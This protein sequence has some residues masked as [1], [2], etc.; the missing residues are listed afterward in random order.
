MGEEN[1]VTLDALND[2][3]IQLKDNGEYKE[4]IKAYVRYLAGRI[5]VL[6]EDHKKTRAFKGHEKILG[7]TH[8]LIRST[9]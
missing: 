1:V 6:G 8:H 7:M 2:L 4:A 9:Q 3:G 5:K